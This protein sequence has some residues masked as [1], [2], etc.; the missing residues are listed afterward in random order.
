LYLELVRELAW[1]LGRKRRRRQL[2]S[3]NCTAQFFKD[4]LA[5]KLERERAEQSSRVVE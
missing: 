1:S 5:K 4:L 3:N 2:C